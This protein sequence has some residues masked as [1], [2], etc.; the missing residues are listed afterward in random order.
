MF[1]VVMD[2]KSYNPCKLDVITFDA[3]DVITTSGFFG[4][5]DDLGELLGG[6]TE[7]M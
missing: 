5:K 4:E 2:K 1:E 3:Q 7:M 6:D